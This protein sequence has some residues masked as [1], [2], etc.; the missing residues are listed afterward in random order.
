[1]ERRACGA[2]KRSRRFQIAACYNG[3]LA[4]YFVLSILAAARVFFSS[5]C[6]TAVE[7][8]ALRQQVAV[9]KRKRPRAPVTTLDRV[10]WTMLRQFWSRWADVLVIVKPETVVGWH[11]AGFRLFWRL[12][13][14]PRGG[15]P[16]ITGEIRELIQR[17]AVE[18]TGWGAPKIHGE[19]QKLGFAISERSVARYLRRIRRR[20]D[21]AKRWLAFLRNHREVIAAFDFF[22]V[23][24]VTFETLYCFFVIEHRRR[25]ILHFNVTR[26]PSSEWVVQQLR[27]AFP[28]AGPYRYVIMDR[29][30]KFD[31]DVVAFLKATGLKPKRT[32]VRAPWQ[33][34]VAERW[35][36]SVRR[37]ILD[38]VI[39]L[40]GQHLRR[41]LRDYVSYF[42]EDRIHDSLGKD[43][44]NKRPIETRP[45]SEAAVIASARLGGLHHRY[46]WRKAA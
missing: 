46:S 12:R 27:E 20:D 24:T 40:G 29:D 45:S 23:P 8:L 3:R 16:K 25:K 19:L 31:G 9:L 18:N 11:R 38:H 21:P 43:T 5:R 13:S 14:R 34:G 35:V 17:L 28:D 39:P 33:N 36:G 41:L 26:H 44:P 4:A 10:F 22:T 42:H 37:E 6:D 2:S 1:M 7:I 30:S 15:R 32:G